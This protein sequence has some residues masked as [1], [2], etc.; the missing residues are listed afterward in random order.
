MSLS[1]TPGAPIWIDLFTPDTDAAAKFYGDLFGW[2]AQEADPRFGG[3][4][5]FEH[6]G[7]PIAGCMKNDGSMGTNAWQVYLESADIKETLEKARANGGKVVFEPMEVADLG[8]QAFVVDPGGAMLGVWQPGVH[9]GISAR[10][11]NGAPS[12]FENLTKNYETVVP[13]YVAVFDWDATTVADTPE[14]R[15]TTLGENEAA[16]AGI[17]DA[18]GFLGDR[19]STWQFYVQVADTD[20]TVAQA[21]AAGATQLMPV[22]D[23]PY[24]RLG[25]LRD[26]AGI[27]FCVMGHNKNSPQT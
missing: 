16:L 5:I 24:G 11:E 12:W 22:D 26:P 13:F 19:P 10:A 27:A 20:A 23:T 18:A 9:Q 6:N 2:T 17:M 1:N 8:T 21:V 7:G 14:F 3:Y 15:Y 25:A 4:F